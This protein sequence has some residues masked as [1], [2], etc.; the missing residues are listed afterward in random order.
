[1]KTFLIILASLGSVSAYAGEAYVPAARAAAVFQALA[2]AFP[3][4]KEGF[5]HSESVTLAPLYCI[6]NEDEYRCTGKN[7]AGVELSLEGGNSIRAE[8][9][10]KLNALFDAMKRA[11]LP[12]V[13]F[14]GGKYI[15]LTHLYCD[16]VMPG[17][18]DDSYECGYM[19]ASDQE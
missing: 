11:N 12:F 9:S 15:S 18:G 13:K 19:E 17:S 4:A 16:H 10:K 7:S 3:Q 1:M 2:S 6:S 14:K 8:E 5:N